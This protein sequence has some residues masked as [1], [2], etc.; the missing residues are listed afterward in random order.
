MTL[1][2]LLY[3]FERAL[4]DMA[5]GFVTLHFVYPYTYTD[6]TSTTCHDS[7]GVLIVCLY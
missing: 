7:L 3:D 5:K 4:Y 1:I 2:M 6:G